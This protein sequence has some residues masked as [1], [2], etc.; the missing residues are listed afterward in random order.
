MCQIILD[1]GINFNKEKSMKGSKETVIYPDGIIHGYPVIFGPCIG[2]KR[3][4]NF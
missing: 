1:F 2:T 3:P 4:G